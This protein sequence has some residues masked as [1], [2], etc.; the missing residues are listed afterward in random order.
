MGKSIGLW[1]A[2]AAMVAA[3]AGCE[4]WNR[5]TQGREATVG[6]AATGAVVGGAV[7]GPVGAVGGAVAGGAI[8][9][10]IGKEPQPP[11]RYTEPG[12]KQPAR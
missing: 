1:V 6:G 12:P 3:L 5:T 9:Q 7:A 8:G 4:T 10:E 11:A 2:A